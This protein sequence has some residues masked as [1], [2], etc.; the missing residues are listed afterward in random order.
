MK[1]GL[2]SSKVAWWATFEG[3]RSFSRKAVVAF[4]KMTA[5][6][7]WRVLAMTSNP[8]PSFAADAAVASRVVEMASPPTSKTFKQMTAQERHEFLLQ[9]VREAMAETA[10]LFASRGWKMPEVLGLD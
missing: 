9:E 7:F 5:E 6:T 2:F 3:G 4:G 8:K 1:K 10:K